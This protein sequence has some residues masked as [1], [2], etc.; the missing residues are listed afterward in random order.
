MGRRPSLAIL[1]IVAGAFFL[2]GLYTAFMQGSS[3]ESNGT[4]PPPASTPASTEP[5]RRQ[6]TLLLLG[7]DDLG[8]EQPNLQAIWFLSYRP[9][10]KDSFLLGVPLDLEVDGDPPAQ[11][12]DLFGLASNGQPTDQFQ[13]RLYQAVPLD[14]D[15]T[16]VLDRTG[17]A[18]AI[19]FVGGVTIDQ[20]TFTGQDVLGILSLTQDDPDAT[21]SLEKRLLTA[22]SQQAA[23]IGSAPEITPLV[24]LIPAHLFISGDITDMVALVAPILPIEPSTTHIELY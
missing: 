16:I 24:D 12:R 21:L 3:G 15:G 10:V 22:M 14:V 23:S 18:A 7:V 1:I 2:I 8:T 6:V 20:A 5:A 4:S 17:F 13:Q 19:D 11:L 9:P